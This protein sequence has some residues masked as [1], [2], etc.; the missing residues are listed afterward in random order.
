M[1]TYI[2]LLLMIVPGFLSRMIYKNLHTESRATS[3]FE[4]TI[5]SLIFSVF[6]I[7]LLVIEALV[8]TIYSLLK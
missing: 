2:A 3:D 4:K 1:E 8:I 7:V 5:M 6:I